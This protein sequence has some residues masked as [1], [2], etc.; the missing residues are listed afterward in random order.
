M[1]RTH[2][3]S[4]TRSTEAIFI[5]PGAFIMGT[6]IEPFYG[7]ALEQ[8]KHAKLDESPIHAV[9]LAPYYIDRFPITNVEY[10]RFIQSTDYPPPA[11]WHGARSRHEEV[12]LPV[13]GVN[14]HDATAYAQWAG[15]RLPTEAEWEKAARGVDGRIYPWGDNF[16]NYI[17]K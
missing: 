17:R 13:V 6:D 2:D 16:G 10:E 11:H 12:N 4:S 8:S 9:N 7:S 1:S 3:D 15:K 14:W 5:P